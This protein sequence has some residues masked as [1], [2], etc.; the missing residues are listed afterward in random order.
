M[1]R[2][3]AMLGAHASRPTGVAGFARKRKRDGA[4]YYRHQLE[5]RF[6]ATKALYRLRNRADSTHAAT[7]ST[8]ALVAPSL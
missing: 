1:P 7:T 2:P 6:A 5:I 3:P 4:G 8:T